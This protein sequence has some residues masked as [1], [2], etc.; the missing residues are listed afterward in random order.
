MHSENG[1]APSREGPR[2]PLFTSHDEGGRCVDGARGARTCEEADATVR[3]PG[4]DL[5]ALTSSAATQDHLG[6]E[7]LRPGAR[8][9][10]S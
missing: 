9:L 4:P 7:Q 3:A 6:P 8:L 10:P 5:Q 2:H 1:T